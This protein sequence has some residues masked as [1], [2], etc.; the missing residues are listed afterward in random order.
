M[1]KITFKKELCKGCG[2]CVAACPKHLIFL[3]NGTLNMK[4][5]NVAAI[6]DEAACIGCASCALMCPDCVI[7]VEK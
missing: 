1:A 3:D 4:G 7:K 5:Y 6:N 2:L